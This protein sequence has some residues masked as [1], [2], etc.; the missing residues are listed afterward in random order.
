VPGVAAGRTR[1]LLGRSVQGGSLTRRAWA[2][3]AARP[4]RLGRGGGRRAR[5]PSGCA[6]EREAREGGQRVG[7]GGERPQG[8]RRRL[9]EAGREQARA[10]VNGSWALVG[11]V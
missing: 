5:R 7:E 10:G 4:G 8:R 2:R 3:A 6:R 9:L 1:A 11:P